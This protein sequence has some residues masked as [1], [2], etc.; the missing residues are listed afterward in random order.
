MITEK[1]YNSPNY[2][3]LA[4]D[5]NAWLPG[6]NGSSSKWYG[7][8]GFERHS[9]TLPIATVADGHST[10]FRVPPYKG[11]GGA[12]VPNYFPGLAD[13]RVDTVSSLWM[14]PGA[15]LYMR[16]YATTPGF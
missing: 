11:G 12:A 2:M 13:C 5:L 16:D 7:N 8:S 14:T 1:E 9:K 3:A 4:S 6:W 10:R 15:E